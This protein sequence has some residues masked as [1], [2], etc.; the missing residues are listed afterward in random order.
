[1]NRFALIVAFCLVISV[2][3]CGDDDD[4]SS[5]AVPTPSSSPSP[6]ELATFTP[7]A[8]PTPVPPGARVIVSQDNGGNP[9]AGSLWVASLDGTTREQLT[10]DGVEATFAGASSDSAVVASLYYVSWDG[11]TERS[12]WNA[13][14]HTQLLAYTSRHSGVAGAMVRSDG[15][16]AAHSDESGSI[17]LVDLSTGEEETLLQGAWEFC[18]RGAGGCFGYDLT[19]WSPDGALLM[20]EK[21]YYEGGDVMIIDPFTDPATVVL[22]PGDD[23]YPSSGVWSPDG[24]AICA[25]GQY[26][27][28]TSIY[29]AR[30][31]DWTFDS[32][33]PEFEEADPGGTDY[34]VSD[35][36][37]LNISHITF[38]D[39]AVE[40]VDGTLDVHT[41]ELRV[42]NLDDRT[43]EV[44]LSEAFD[45]P[46]SQALY[47]LGISESQ[48][49]L[50]R[51]AEP[52]YPGEEFNFTNEV[53]EVSTGTRIQVLEPGDRVVAVAPS[54]P[55]D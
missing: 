8:A 43:Q 44:I 25:W 34:W 21:R 50:G 22:P 48:V 26:A 49:L 29:V 5:T 45:A 18:E 28:P 24:Q 47:V 31:P 54:A 36:A 53:V 40:H 11:E 30:A 20:L 13:T 1:M 16:F 4:E 27:A 52:L 23:F 14:S 19:G 35:C 33:T 3:A 15:R 7:S 46:P 9:Y 32:Q 39:D 6:T 12:L 17:L 37:W 10:P 42:L 51:S 38:T 41:S 55:N 2:T